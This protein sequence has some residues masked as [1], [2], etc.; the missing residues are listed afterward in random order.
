[1]IPCLSS[2]F[3]DTLANSEASK[4][5]TTQATGHAGTRDR[6]LPIGSTPGDPNGFARAK[7]GTSNSVP[8]TVYQA[9]VMP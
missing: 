8:P 9:G 1:M 6:I 4:H 3:A 7:V 2:Y 5:T